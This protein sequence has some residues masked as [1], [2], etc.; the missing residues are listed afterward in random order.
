MRSLLIYL[1]HL[2]VFLSLAG[3]DGIE[4]RNCRR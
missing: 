3:L 2:M 4:R 1:L